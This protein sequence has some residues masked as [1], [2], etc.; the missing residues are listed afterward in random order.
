AMFLRKSG[1]DEVGVRLRQICQVR[2]RSRTAPY[3]ARTYRDQRLGNVIARSPRIRIRFAEADQSL[4]L[5][6][7]H[8]VPGDRETQTCQENHRQ[9]LLQPH[10]TEEESDNRDWNVGKRS[11]QIW[12]GEDHQE[13]HPYDRSGF[14]EV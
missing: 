4:L 2:L 9:C 8:V 3:S 5:V 6:V 11:A 14:D 1:E 13:W 10:A 12:L 7:L